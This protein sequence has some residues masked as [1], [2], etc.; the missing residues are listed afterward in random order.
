VIRAFGPSQRSCSFSEVE[1]LKGNG[2]SRQA[3]SL[4][5]D[6]GGES[7]F[8]RQRVMV[9]I[10][11]RAVGCGAQKNGAR[12]GENRAPA[13]QKRLGEIRRRRGKGAGFRENCRSLRF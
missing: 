9:R 1:W 12:L 10:P 7:L 3:S 8:S 4:I 6:R 2:Q 11:P 13:C 5:G